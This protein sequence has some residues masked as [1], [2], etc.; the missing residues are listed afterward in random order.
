MRQVKG[1]KMRRKFFFLSYFRQNFVQ[2]TMLETS[3]VTWPCTLCLSLLAVFVFKII[4]TFRRVTIVLRELVS[5]I[6]LPTPFPSI[7]SSRLLSFLAFSVQDL[8]SHST[9]LNH[10]DSLGLIIS[11]IFLLLFLGTKK[12]IF[13]LDISPYL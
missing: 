4:V 3:H 13:F 7:V 10:F 11:D 5:P 1:G 6:C 2:C 9:T 12:S 8:L